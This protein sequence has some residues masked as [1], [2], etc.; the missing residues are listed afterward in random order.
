[1]QKL[2]FKEK[3]LSTEMIFQGRV[4]N[5]RVDQVELPNKEKGLREVVEHPGAVA[6][7]PVLEDG[8][9]IMV[10]QF[11]YPVNRHVLEIPAGK[12][13]PGENPDFCAI[14]ELEEETGYKAG[15][16]KKVLPLLTT[17][18]F[19][20]EVIHLYLA[21]EL[22]KTKQNLDEDE[23]LNIEIVQQKDLTKMLK[24]GEI[25]DAKTIAGLMMLKIFNAD[26]E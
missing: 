4:L 26:N 15:K 3:Q 17:P 10:R 25:C 7:V 12:L 6:I 1:M 5:L 19:S 24:N 11:R 20:D 2:D 14:R 22:V 9:I 18:G 21:K 13:D 23:F 16:I 8:S